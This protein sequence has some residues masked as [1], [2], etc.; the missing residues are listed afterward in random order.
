[1]RL[2]H[3]ADWHL[4]ASLGGHSRDAEHALFLAWLLDLLEQ[5]RAD[6]L[7]LAGDVFDQGNPPA[8]AWRLWYDFLAQA[9][10]RLP[11][12]SLVVL[13]G[14]H[15]AA[16]R[17][18]APAP[19]LSSL[20][21]HVL[22]GMP[23]GV[24]GT[25]DPARAVVPLRGPSGEVEAVVAAVPFLRAPD[26]VAPLSSPRSSPP[27]STLSSPPSSPARASPMDAVA[28]VTGAALAAAAAVRRPGQ[29]LLAMGHGHLLGGTLSADS[30]RATYQDAQPMPASVFGPEV[31]YVAFGHLHRAQTI[32]GR[33]E[34]RYAGSPLPLTFTERHYAHQVLVVDVAG[35]DLKE[36]RARTVP[37]AA[38]LVRVPEEPAPLEEVLDRLRALDAP[39]CAEVH[40]PL[41]EV[42]VRLH[43]PVVDLRARVEQALEGKAVRLV[44]VQVLHEGQGG[45]LGAGEA[46]ASLAEMAPAVVLERLY[47]RTYGGPVPALLSA[48]F[49]ELVDEV[50]AERNR[51]VPPV[52]SG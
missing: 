6:A 7:L 4:G 16:A 37:R 36:V 27:S 10:R 32:E 49:A 38:P 22:G 15:D 14:N 25:P 29:A 9:T 13:G 17:L 8:S 1:M 44:R 51:T 3:T 23:R 33:R 28:V 39:A 46:A 50:L 42:R 5:E 41:V 30:E 40:Q 2:V 48:A 47:Q 20:S 35:E 52:G 19:L 43:A 18:E 45:S 11:R 26:L 34:V 12:L 31:A 21:V 24:D